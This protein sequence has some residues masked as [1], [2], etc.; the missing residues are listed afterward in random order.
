MKDIAR[1]AGVH[2]TTVSRALRNDPHLP[3]ATRARIQNLARELGYRPNPLVSALVALRR[4]RH[5]PAVESCLGYVMRAMPLRSTCRR[6]LDGARSEAA[7]LGY[8][9]E[10]FPVGEG[11]CPAWR[12]ERMLRTRNI[13]GLLLGPLPE[14][15][16]GFAPNWDDFAVVAL[17]R[18]PDQPAF[19]RVAHDS[20]AGMRTVMEACRSRAR[21]RVGLVLT[22][23]DQENTQRTNGAALLVEQQ[24]DPRFE[25][26]P[27]LILETW[28]PAAFARW[29]A[30]HG[31][32]ALVTSNDL[33]PDL[34]A[35]HRWMPPFE[36]PL[37]L[38][39]DAGDGD[40]HP[41]IVQAA[42]EIGAIATRLLVDKLQRN[43]RGVP[44]L[45][46]T[47]LVP[48]RW[49]DGSV[50]PDAAQSLTAGG[51]ESVPPSVAGTGFGSTSN[52]A[53]ARIRTR[54]LANTN[55]SPLRT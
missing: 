47:V 45:P 7:K 26:V 20:Y 38:N 3:A 34:E 12:L 31:P 37:L 13:S 49:T 25:A 54:R 48:G 1:L 10:V 22:M 21:W 19:D 14:A 4:L 50:A 24:A 36:R 51:S 39:I 52:S 30:L 6:H 29:Q 41:G 8:K 35:W 2:Q 46:Q 17:E 32:T 23:T 18:T 53:P 15:R 9:V 55:Q 40:G 33:L 44:A 11:P 16:G 43:E 5:K 42:A 28:D 27:P